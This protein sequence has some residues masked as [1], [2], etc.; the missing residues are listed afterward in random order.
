M[1]VGL[2]FSV[3]DDDTKNMTV[4]LTE[5][6]ET[7]FVNDRCLTHVL[8]KDD[9]SKD[10]W[11]NISIKVDCRPANAKGTLTPSAVKPIMISTGGETASSTPGPSSMK[12]DTEIPHQYGPKGGTD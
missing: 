2:T 10:S 9:P 12:P 8:L 5:M 11:G 4:P 3:A 6:V 7:V 1:K